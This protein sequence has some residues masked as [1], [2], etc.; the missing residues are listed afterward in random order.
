[1]NT[2][3]AYYCSDAGCLLASAEGKL[4]AGNVNGVLQLWAVV[5][6][7]TSTG[8]HPTISLKASMDI[9]SGMITSAS[10]NKN[11]ELVRKYKTEVMT[12]SSTTV[13][14]HGTLFL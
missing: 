14:V 1:M 3:Q 8:T 12:L 4:L 2:V 11:M 5:G 13:H 9:D 6:Q 10:F 7:T